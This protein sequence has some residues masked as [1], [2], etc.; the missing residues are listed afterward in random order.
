M[1][2]R[3]RVLEETFARGVV[4]R[5]DGGRIR[6]P[7]NTIWEDMYP[8]LQERVEDDR[9]A[10]GLSGMWGSGHVKGSDISSEPKPRRGGPRP[11]RVEPNRSRVAARAFPVL[12][13]GRVNIEV[14][15]DVTETESRLWTDGYIVVSC[16]CA[17]EQGDV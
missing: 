8:E 17:C 9:I 5:M 10:G 1:V 4:D 2:C 16:G 14:V 13:G 6:L 11:K 3:S 12:D 7:S 15:G